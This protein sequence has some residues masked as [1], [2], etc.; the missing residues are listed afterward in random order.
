[1]TEPFGDIYK[2]VFSSGI[3]AEVWLRSDSPFVWV[4]NVLQLLFVLS[5]GVVMNFYGHPF[6]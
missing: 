1:M 5:T 4:I 2:C 3:K 6:V